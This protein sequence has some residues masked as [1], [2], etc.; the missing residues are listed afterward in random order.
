VR[1]LAGR[2]RE[3][4]VV[5]L[6]HNP[7]FFEEASGLVALQLSGHTHGGQVN[8]GG[9]AGALLPY[10]AGRYVRNGSTLYVS[11]GIGITGAPV[12]LAAAP[13]ITRLVLTA[14]RV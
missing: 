2:D 10:V 13:E 3:A 4:P 7:V 1:A 11:R 5:L 8:V 12:R 14:G 6:A 9:V